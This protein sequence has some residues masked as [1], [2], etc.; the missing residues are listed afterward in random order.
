M[1]GLGRA[2][3]RRSLRPR[4]GAIFFFRNR[5]LAGPEPATH[6]LILIWSLKS[7]SDQMLGTALAATQAIAGNRLQSRPALA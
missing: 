6:K 4:S 7:Q 1:R 5:S 2:E 3:L